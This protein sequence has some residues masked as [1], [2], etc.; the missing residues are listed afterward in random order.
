M[1]TNRRRFLSGSLVGLGGLTAA[2]PAV[3][4]TRERLRAE[5]ERQYLEACSVDSYHARLRALVEAELET[6]EVPEAERQ[7]LLATACPFC[8]CAIGSL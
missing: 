4:L 5:T 3:A 2:G 1:T 8:G 6:R 7:A